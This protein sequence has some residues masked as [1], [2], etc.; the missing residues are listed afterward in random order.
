MSPNFIGDRGLSDGANSQSLGRDIL[1]QVGVEIGALAA[2]AMAILVGEFPDPFPWLEFL[3]T[4]GAIAATRSF[5]LPLPGKGFASFVLGVMLFAVLR[6]GWHWAV[7]TGLVG[8]PIGDIALRRLKLRAALANAGHVLFGTA[9]VGLLYERLGGA[10]GSAAAVVAAPNAPALAALLVVLA[11]LIN[12]TFY[13]EL[14]AA[15]AV[16]FVDVRLTMRWEAVVYVMSA[17][18]AL[19]WLWGAAVSGGALYR[20]AVLAVLFALTAGAHWM[21]RTGVKADELRLLHR[22]SRAI[23]ADVD[24]KRNFAT[25]QQLTRQLVPWD[26]MGFAIYDESRHEM[27]LVADTDP[28]LKIGTRY[29]ADFGLTGEALRRRGP[30]VA[31]A[32]RRAGIVG[33]EVRGSEILIP[34]HQGERVVGVWSVRH[35]DPGMYRDLD[36]AL[37]GSLAPQLALALRLHALIAP[38]LDSSEQTAQYVEHLTATSQQIHASSQE[39]TAATQRAEAGAVRAADLVGEAERAMQDLREAAG[40]AAAAGEE[41]HRAAQAVEAAAQAVRSGTQRT[42]AALETVGATVDESAAEVARL[43]EAADKVGRFAETIGAIA[44]QTNMLALNATIEAARAGAQGA[45]FAVVADEVRRLAEESGR[46]AAQAARTTAETRR[47]LDHAAQLLERMRSELTG[48]ADAAR[49]WIAELEEIT[50]ASEVASSTSTKMVEFPRRN[51]QRVNEMQRLLE[52]LRRAA[53]GSAAEAQVVAAAAAEQ[54]QAIEN[55]SRS[56]IQLSGN[57]EQL[58]RAARLVRS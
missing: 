16:A 15:H 39:V 1:I 13:L 12:A 19:G 7:V 41:T 21:A 23:A 18:L 22:L 25:I 20:V 8:M 58:A 48:V 51:M 24:L 28:A 4:T 9:L 3:L 54:L 10:V 14:A 44:N 27:E 29:S 33:G 11:V 31:A 34:L 40:E 53:Q 37:L 17:L 46:E 2:I 36:A 38:L 50:R 52:D 30:V 32:G 6:H 42:A 49:S 57:A 56:A 5:G 26:Q 45:G 35:A 47:V 43:R 55:L